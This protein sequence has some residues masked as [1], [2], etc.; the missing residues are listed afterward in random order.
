MVFFVTDK[1]LPDIALLT[2][3]VQKSSVIS[4]TNRARVSLW[5]PPHPQAKALKPCST[6]LKV[7]TSSSLDMRRSQTRLSGFKSESELAAG[8][9]R[10]Q[11]LKW[12]AAV[13]GV[14][15][16]SIAA[17]VGW[18][19]GGA[20]NASIQIQSEPVGIQVRINGDVRGRTPLALTLAPG[21]Y[22]VVLGEGDSAERRQV[23]LGDGEKSSLQYVVR[24]TALET[25]AAASAVAVTSALSVITEPAGG[26]VSIDGVDRGTAPIV[27]GHLSAGDH[28]LV[29]RNQ[30]AVY[31]RAV[32]LQAGVT[33]TVVVGTSLAAAAGWLTVQTPLPLQIHEAG[34]LDRPDGD[35]TPDADAGRS[36]AHTVRRENRIPRVSRGAH[37]RGPD[38]HPCPRGPAI[39]R[40]LQRHSRGPRSSWTASAPGKH[41]S[42]ITCC[43]WATI[44]LNCVTRSS[45]PGAR[46]FP[47]R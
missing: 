30:G 43:R 17:V 1:S 31:Q 34:G 36:P 33:S 18:R 47:C 5:P 38:D 37:H 16:L 44:R 13:L 10:Q 40:E 25:A 4:H 15:V 7:H 29:V 24:D 2:A 21:T 41:R 11:Y 28:R 45:A 39:R 35:L 14:V 9:R 46:R 20:S 42:A 32:T 22:E 6:A 27:V 26:A 19:G 3:E 12:G 23:V 8:L